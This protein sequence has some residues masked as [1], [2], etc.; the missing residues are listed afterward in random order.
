MVLARIDI[1]LDVAQLSLIVISLLASAAAWYH[2]RAVRRI[3][4]DEKTR[5]LR[6]K[7]RD[8]GEKP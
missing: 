6:E 2:A 3:A 5:R 8:M 7:L 1:E 4:T